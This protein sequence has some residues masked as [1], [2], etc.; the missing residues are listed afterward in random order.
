MNWQDLFAA[1]ALVMVIEGL[2]P[3]SSPQS[4]RRAYLQVTQLDD[5]TI[6]CTGLASMV[7]GMILLF[8]IR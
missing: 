6:R 7:I 4:L 3:F 1:I 5:M 8:L 2:L